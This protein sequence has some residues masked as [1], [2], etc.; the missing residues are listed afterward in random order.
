MLAAL[1]RFGAEAIAINPIDEDWMEQIREAS[2]EI[3]FLGALHGKGGEDG[4]VQG[5]LE[6]F[7]YAYT[8]SGGTRKRPCHQ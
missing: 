6:T 5:V 1:Q 3:A 7:E 4:T 2:I 8:G